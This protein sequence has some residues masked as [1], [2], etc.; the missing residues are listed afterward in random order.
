VRID[1]CTFAKKIFEALR[2]RE[3]SKEGKREKRVKVLKFIGLEESSRRTSKAETE[4]EVTEAWIE[5]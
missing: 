3:E 4:V 1:W 2:A 5:T